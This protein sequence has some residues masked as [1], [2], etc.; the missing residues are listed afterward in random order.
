[1]QHQSP[2]SLMRDPLLLGAAVAAGVIVVGVA[3]GGTVAGAAAGAGPS[4]LGVVVVAGATVVGA[5]AGAV[6][7]AATEVG[8]AV[9]GAEA[10]ATVAGDELAGMRWA[11]SS[12]SDSRIHPPVQFERANLSELGVAGFDALSVANSRLLVFSVGSARLLTA[13]ALHGPA[14]IDVKRVPGNFLH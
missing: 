12:Y 4:L 8:V 2:Q 9:A 1:M 3:A 5:A 13:E 6:V 14:F 7:G 11:G 10:G